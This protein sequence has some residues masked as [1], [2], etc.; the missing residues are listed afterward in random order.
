MTPSRRDV[1]ALVG[2]TTAA[3]AGVAGSATISA[4]E[5]TDDLPA[6]SQ[7][8]TIEDGGLEFV[9]L[10]WA[11]LED[12]AQREL[13]EAGPDEAVP[14]EYEADPMVAPVSNGMLAAYF[15]VGLDLAQYRLGRLVDEAAFESTVEELLLVNDVLIVTGAIDPAEIDDEL[16]AEPA[17]D[18]LRQMER[19][20]EIGDYDVYTPIDEAAD[21]VIAVSSD[22]IVFVDSDALEDDT[23]P[24]ARLETTIA[25]TA[26][27]VDRATEV[28]DVV[29]WLVETAGDG[30]AVVGQYGDRI[31]ADANGGVTDVRFE[32]FEDADGVI[33]SFTAEDAETG[34]GEFAAI[35]DDPD[36][37]ELEALLGSSADERSVD[38]DEN[39]VTAAGTWREVN[40]TVTE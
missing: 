8:L 7:W 19:T 15:T 40:G 35:V 2:A 3:T 12:E 26:G 10:D 27:D 5:D 14:A 39:R 23:D 4:Q 29:A 22:A 25:V 38:I 36:E 9:V 18:F 31:V 21:A 32:G 6:Y 28:S 20:D 30:D 13:E 34:T 1:L 11:D 16:T 33:T 24:M 17:A 37:D